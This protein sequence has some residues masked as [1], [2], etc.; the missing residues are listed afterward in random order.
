MCSTF[1]ITWRR[2][3]P[4][5][6]PP[7]IP[8]PAELAFG[9]ADAAFT[10]DAACPLTLVGGSEAGLLFSARELQSAIASA[11]GLELPI[12]KSASPSAGIMLLLD[13]DSDQG[14]EGYSISVA[15]GVV[16]VSA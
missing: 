6:P 15:P 4:E 14:P 13:A 11:T 2:P 5:Q 7:L 8:A 12:R 9:A 10:I 3:V 1:P 16:T